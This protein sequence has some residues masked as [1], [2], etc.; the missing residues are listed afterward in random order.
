MDRI[1]N[2]LRFQAPP[3][4]APQIAVV[5]VGGKILSVRELTRHSIDVRRHHQPVH[6][7]ETPAASNEFGGQPIKQF[8]VCRRL[9]L[10]P[11][12]IG[13]ADDPTP[14]MPLPKAIDNYPGNKW[15]VGTRKPKGQLLAIPGAVRVSVLELV[16]TAEGGG[17]PGPTLAL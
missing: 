14:E 4:G 15:M 16:P 5:F 13:A 3:V 8:G 12:I 9:A 17:R 2:S 7:F 10:P 11:E 6:R 1:P